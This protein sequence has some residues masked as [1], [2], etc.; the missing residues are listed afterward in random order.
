LGDFD[1][2]S[3]DANQVWRDNVPGQSGSAISA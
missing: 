1:E 2:G 3:A